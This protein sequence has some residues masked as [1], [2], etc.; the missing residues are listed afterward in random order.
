MTKIKK[1][2]K[3]PIKEW[4]EPEFNMQVVKKTDLWVVLT[5][6]GTIILVASVLI[7][8]KTGCIG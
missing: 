1:P 5:V 6:F 4:D 2:M 3:V 8:L 7:L